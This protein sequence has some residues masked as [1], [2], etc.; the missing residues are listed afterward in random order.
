MSARA[1]AV[2]AS[3]AAGIG[4]AVLAPVVVIGGVGLAVWAAWQTRKGRR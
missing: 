4:F 2:T 1:R 3:V